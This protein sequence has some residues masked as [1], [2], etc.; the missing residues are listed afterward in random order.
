MLFII[1]NYISLIHLLVFYH[2][3][4]EYSLT[5]WFSSVQIHVS[6]AD[7]PLQDPSTIVSPLAYFLRASFS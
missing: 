4:L 3:K 7:S 6:F 1:V 2:Y 5:H